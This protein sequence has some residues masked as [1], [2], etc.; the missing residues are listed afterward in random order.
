MEAT[1][2]F[3][4]LKGHQYISL[5]TYRKSGEGVATPVWFAVDGDRMFIVTQA[6]SGKVKRIR[7]NPRVTIAPSDA[8]GKVKP[9]AP[10]I[11]GVASVTPMEEGGRGDRALRGKYGFMYRAFAWYWGLRKVVPVLL[12]VRPA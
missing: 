2:I 5:T 10:Q 9:G 6:E 11:E 8:Q 12:E 7:N 3:P 1:Q 4:Q